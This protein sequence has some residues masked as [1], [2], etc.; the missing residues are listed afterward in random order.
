MRAKPAGLRVQL[1]QALFRDPPASGPCLGRRRGFLLVPAL[2]G[3]A[4]VLQLLRVGWSASLDSLWA[5]DGQIFLH[6]A[7]F[8]GL[9]GAVTSPY[10]GYLV[11][12]PRLIGEAATLLPLQHA[13]AVTAILAATVVALSG[14][15]VWHAA[16]GLIRNSYL[17]GLLAL[18]TVL[19][20][21]AGLE[22]I[23]SAAYV[24]WY[25]LFATFWLLLWRPRTMP[26]AL[27][28]ALFVLATALSTPGVWFLL[29]LAALRV[30]AIR[31]RRDLAI[32]GAYALGAAIQIPIVASNQG[33]AIDPSWTN[34]I[35]VAY[36]Q[37]ILDGAAFGQELGGSLW[38]HLGWPFL[39]ASGLCA[40]ALLI[41]LL[42]DSGPTGR[43]FAA[44]AVPT[45][46]VLFV[47]SVYQRAVGGSMAWP[48]D[49][50]HGAGGR[51]T[52]VP[53]LL[54]ISA[55]FVLIEDSSR[56]PRG[57]SRPSWVGVGLAA[58]L[59]VAVATSFSQADRANRGTPPWEDALEAAAA[60]CR[61]QS[62]TEVPVAISPPGFG[63]QVPC[64]RI[65]SLGEPTAG[66]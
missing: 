5:E 52:I 36:A 63:L 21:V 54:L 35:W 51:Y 4:V 22:S 30:A 11:V 48:L 37:R 57:T 58:L 40:V 27:L 49:S 38:A 10:A 2:L 53:A 24:P 8:E 9:S 62:A 13:G 23:D 3:L 29:P 59:L 26:G 41:A 7:L 64:D 66:R 17:R 6:G 18:A 15:A 45:S 16:A 44:L 39:V 47:V 60:S 20:P 34:E 33:E 14:L 31:D 43:W 46:L 61:A 12:V 50:F 65:A 28:G 42:R 32:V 1:N 56:K 55:A 19:P 25:M